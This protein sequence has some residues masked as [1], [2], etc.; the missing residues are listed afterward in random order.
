MARIIS[1]PASRFSRYPD[2]L[3]AEASD[4]RIAPGDW[5]HTIVVHDTESSERF[6][7][8]RYER[9]RD[10]DITVVIYASSAARLTLY[11]D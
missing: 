4:L 9:D 3:Y 1:V 6:T 10:G 7:F 11:N 8:V 2:S 5:P